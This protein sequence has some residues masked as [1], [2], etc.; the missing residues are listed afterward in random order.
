MKKNIIYFICVAL[1]L[2]SCSTYR[3]SQTPDDVYYSPAKKVVPADQYDE[4]QSYTSSSDD[5]YLRMKVADHYRWSNLDDFDYWYDSRY[6]YNNY[7]S[8]YNP[9]NT[10]YSPWGVSLAYN[11]YN[12]YTSFWYSPWNSVYCPAYTVV[13]YKNPSVYY[14]TRTANSYHLSTY[15]NHNYNNTNMPMRNGSRSNVYINGNSSRRNDN[16]IINQNRNNSNPVRL[17]NNNNNSNS[18][19]NSGSSHNMSSGGSSGGGMSRAP[20]GGH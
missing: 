18:N 19:F 17:F 20:R 4:Y 2:T 8:Y 15:S 10:Y 16:Y 1:F 11:F 7:Y 9:W 12:P 5:D 3:S 6:Y 14:G 13:Y